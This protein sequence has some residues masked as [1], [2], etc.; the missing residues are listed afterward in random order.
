MHRIEMNEVDQHIAHVC[1]PERT[2][3][4]WVLVYRNP[5]TGNSW[6]AMRLLP[7]DNARAREA[8]T[9]QGCEVVIS[10][11]ENGEWNTWQW[12]H[13]YRKDAPMAELSAQVYH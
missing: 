13:R 1:D 7:S 4:R 12:L 10:N 3:N 5:H 8:L 9:A 6:H 11:L 2:D